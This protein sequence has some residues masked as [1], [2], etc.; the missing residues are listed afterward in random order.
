M[1]WWIAI[2]LPAALAVLVAVIDSRREQRVDQTL[3]SWRVNP[4]NF[5]DYAEEEKRLQRELKEISAMNFFTS[6]RARY[7]TIKVRHLLVVLS[8]SFGFSLSH[9]ANFPTVRILG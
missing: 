3:A 7:M 4:E 9:A 6:A 8:L 5:E 1:S 2:G